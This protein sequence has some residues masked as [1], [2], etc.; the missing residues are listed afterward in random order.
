MHEFRTR[1]TS[2]HRAA[3]AVVIAAA[4]VA[5]LTSAAPSALAA[6]PRLSGHLPRR[7]DRRLRTVQPSV[8][9]NTAG[10]CRGSAEQGD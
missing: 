4:A 10:P 5:A 2:P 1:Q 8:A 9:R 3:V 6:D 7:H